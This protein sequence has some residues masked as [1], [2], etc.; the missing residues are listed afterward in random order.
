[1]RF[2]ARFFGKKPD[3]GKETDPPRP[4]VVS[5]R[6]SFPNQYTAEQILATS[7]S[8]DARFEAVI[9]LGKTNSQ[10]VVPALAKA[11]LSDPDTYVRRSAAGYLGSLKGV[12]AE[13]ALLQAKAD[14]DPSV[15]KK[16][17]EALFRVGTERARKAIGDALRDTDPEVQAEAEK[18]V[19]RSSRKISKRLCPFLSESGMCEPPGVS[20]AHECSW[21][22]QGRGHY[23][24]CF[25]H[26]MHTHPGGPADFM[27]KHLMGSH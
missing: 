9:A 15:R 12:E 18:Y 23:K 5:V 17:V 24:D 14:P 10:L 2:L 20:D 25:V 1:M 6:T 13:K 22:T 16:I 19:S 7:E 8:S 21:E 27:R 3:S 11:L 26:K 4:Q